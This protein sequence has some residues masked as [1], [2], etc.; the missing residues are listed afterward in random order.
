MKIKSFVQPV[1]NINQSMVESKEN[2]GIEHGDAKTA[3]SIER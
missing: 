2:Q 3:K 1:R